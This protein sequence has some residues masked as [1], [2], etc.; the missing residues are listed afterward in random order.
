MLHQ[1]LTLDK[2]T[3]TL[4]TGYRK[5]K[6]ILGNTYTGEAYTSLF[7]ANRNSTK[8]NQ[9]YELRALSNFDGPF[10]F[11]AG[12]SYS[13]QD[14]NMLAYATVGLS[15]LVTFVD[16]NRNDG[17]PPPYFN[18]AGQLNL[19]P[20]FQDD[21]AMTGAK[22]KS[23]TTAFYVDANYDLTDRLRFTAGVRYTDDQKDFLRRANPGGPCTALTPVQDQ[24]LVN[25]E[26][27]DARSNA[28]SRVGNGFTAKDLKPFQIPLPGSA[29]GIDSK[30]NDSWS[31]VTYRAVVDYHLS[32][33]NMV[34]VSYATGFIPGGYTE[35]CSSLATCQPFDS[36]TNW[37]AEV[38]FKGRFLDNML[39]TNVAMYY[40]K[41]SDLIRS[42]VLPFT[43]AFGV[44]TQETVNVNAGTSIAKGV[45]LEGTWLG[46]R[47]SEV[48]GDVC[49]SRSPVR[50]LQSQRPG[51]V[52]PR[53]TV[54]TEVQVG[55]YGHVRPIVGKRGLAV[56]TAASTAIR[57]SSRCQCSIHRGRR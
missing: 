52:Q 53:R 19:D 33:D 54:L 57:T 3:Y 35:T 44:T 28:L 20:S 4:F 13:V 39:Q 38:G 24:V 6:E 51:S 16:Q 30:F 48:H 14:V 27:L 32:D 50:Q 7:D 2:M 18:A 12:T 8:E 40:T 34:Y 46:D 37:N 45:E 56:S 55:R 36:E 29:F 25:G 17:I 23:K 26:C 43:D 10:S 22:Q 49:V 41:Y 15:S 47:Q 31:K 5:Q 9:Q 11:V 21:L 1:K 42:Q